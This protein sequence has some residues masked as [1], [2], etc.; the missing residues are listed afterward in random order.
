MQVPAVSQPPQVSLAQPD[1][2]VVHFQGVVQQGLLSAR[3]MEFS[4]G[5]AAKS[6]VVRLSQ[7]VLTLLVFPLR[8]QRTTGPSVVA[9]I[10]PDTTNIISTTFFNTRLLMTTV[11]AARRNRQHR[12]ILMARNLIPMENVHN[13]QPHLTNR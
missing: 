2:V 13:R 6:L 7:T 8:S 12:H 10:R 4:Q 5:M 3:R 9:V 1:Q 11:A